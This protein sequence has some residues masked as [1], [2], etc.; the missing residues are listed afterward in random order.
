MERDR[1]LLFGV[2]AVQ[3]NKVSPLKLIEIAAVWATDPSRSLSQRLVEAGLLSSRDQQMIGTLVDEAVRAHGGNASDTLQSLGGNELLQRSYLGTLELTDSGSILTRPGPQPAHI[4]IGELDVRAVEETPG[5]YSN[6]SEYARGG[7]GR[8]LLVHDQHFG[9]NVALK[10]LLPAQSSSPEAATETPISPVRLSAPYVARFLQEARIT[11][12]LEHPSI[13]P[14]YEL[15]H[16][17]DGTL[18]YTMKLVRGQTLSKTLAQA[19]ALENRLKF[20]NHFLGLCHAIAYAHDRGVIHRDIKPGNVMVGEFGETVVIDWGLAKIKGQNDL[21]SDDLQK[22]LHGLR[23]GEETELTKTTYG[24][25]LGTPNYMP[26]EQALGQIDHVDERSDVYALGAVLYELLTGKPPYNASTVQGILDRVISQSPAPIT[27]L[28]PNAPAELVAICERAMQRRPEERYQSAKE[29]AAEV[30]RFLTGAMVQAYS[31]GF[32]EHLR[33]FVKRHRAAVTTT[34]AAAAAVMVL[35]ILSY[36]Q[37]VQAKDEALLARDAEREQREVAQTA[38]EKEESLREEAQRQLYTMSIM[39]A[40]SKVEDNRYDLV[41]AALAKAPEPLRGWEWHY[42]Q[43]L[44][45][46]DLATL[47][48]HTQA[49]NDIALDPSGTRLATASADGTCKLWDLATNR[50]IRT[51]NG[52]NGPAWA[53]AYSRDGKRLAT[54]S[55]AGKDTVVT[56][57]DADTGQAIRSL[58]QLGKSPICALPWGWSADGR[59][60]LIADGTTGNVS[61]ADATTGEGVRTIQ[62]YEK[63]IVSVAFSGQCDRIITIGNDGTA[64][65]IAGPSAKVWETA[66]GKLLATLEGQN[67]S[68]PYAQFSPDDRW[69]AVNCDGGSGRGNYARVCDASN[70]AQ[71]AELHGHSADITDIKFSPTRQQIIT[72]GKDGIANLWE[73]ASGELLHTLR[74]HQRLISKAAFNGDGTRL[75]TVSSDNTAKVWDVASGRELATLA[76][77][78]SEVLKGIFSPD[79][80]RIITAS[81]D[82]TAKVWDAAE[83]A[84]PALHTLSGNT[85]ATLCAV[86]SPDGRRIATVSPKESWSVKVWDTATGAELA[87]LP[88]SGA[89]ISGLAFS[90]DGGQLLT[91]AAHDSKARVWE[92]PSTKEIHTLAAH[93]DIL[94]MCAYSP[95][96]SRIV[97]ASHDKTTKLWDAASGRE[98]ATLQGHTGAVF[99][100]VFSPDGTRVITASGDT[101]ARI[102][103]AATGQ[104]L[105]T[106]AGH[107]KNVPN[108]TFS[109]DSKRAVTASWD[110][111]A[112]VWDTA[113]GRELASL[114]H[115]GQVSHALFSPDGRRIASSSGDYF[116]YLWS[117][118]SYERL[119]TLPCDREVWDVAFSPDST[120]IVTASGDGNVRVWDTET[121]AN[122]VTLVGHGRE[123]TQVTFSPDGKYILSAAKDGTVKLWGTT[124][125]YETAAATGGLVSS[126]TAPH[127]GG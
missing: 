73:T 56:F 105:L 12:Q 108:A 11:G 75:L 93:T 78:Q 50:E 77:H 69:I 82:S 32:G 23:L 106:L 71:V 5:R 72:V 91:T 123:V 59:L 127:Q 85:R 94:N 53:V 125:P 38:R 109:P 117:A 47:K 33:R 76:G 84:S 37:V 21:I 114:P 16:R 90:P 81:D 63:R 2:F 88:G 17:R 49:I 43:R 1:N 74:G 39:L 4:E 89:N 101:T 112:K 65:G 44:C 113:T 13:V 92:V 20:V 55:G 116:A 9:R 96:G 22:T 66:T 70:Y 119:A 95:D 8:V 48:G 35:G 46:L 18:Y 97:T 104:S 58:N 15:G 14:V 87:T 100:A 27:S 68:A 86:F 29:L 102:W 99:S 118:E 25:A 3:L 115:D 64:G 80:M 83:F 110:H 7:M 121:G 24:H 62:C 40:E 57:W 30:D 10:E 60:F 41:E 36:V 45:H 98:L 61:V 28:E 124:A 26:P 52:K 54:I 122:L 31:Y 6:I 42:L 19:G 126:P 103:D 120:R 51:L 79:G 111:T 107:S 67:A 34:A